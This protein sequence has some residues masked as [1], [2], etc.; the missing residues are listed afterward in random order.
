MDYKSAEADELLVLILV[1]MECRR[2]KTNSHHL[3]ASIWVLILV[4]MECRRKGDYDYDK[5]VYQLS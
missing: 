3:R 1:V 4:V 5:E 2:K